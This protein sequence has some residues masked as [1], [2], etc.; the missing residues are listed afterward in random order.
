[1]SELDY[2]IEPE[3]ECPNNDPDHAAF[4]RATATIRLHD[5]IEEFVACKMY[6]LAAGFGFESVPPGM[7]PVSRV[8]TPLPLFAMGNV[9]AE[10][11]AHVLAEIETEAE[12]VLGSFRP[13]E[14]DALCMENIPNGGHLNWVLEQMGVTYAPHTFL[15]L[16]HHRQLSRNK[17]LRCRRN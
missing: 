7:T 1:M 4:I 9:A 15:A 10:H 2:A 13:K 6:L 12:T 14:Y 11:A 3:V 16:K 8:E 5:A 17:W